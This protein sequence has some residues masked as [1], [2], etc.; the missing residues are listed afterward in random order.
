MTSNASLLISTVILVVLLAL[1]GYV[2]FSGAGEA[3]EDV[4]C[5][6]NPE[7]EECRNGPKIF[8]RRI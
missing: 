4:S 6:L 1:Y 5:A 2:S 3:P 8:E 7:S